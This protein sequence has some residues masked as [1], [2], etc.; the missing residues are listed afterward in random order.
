MEKSKPERHATYNA[1]QG[2]KTLLL[3]FTFL[4]S[5][6]CFGQNSVY[7]Y[8]LPPDPSVWTMDVIGQPQPSGCG[9]YGGTYCGSYRDRMEGDT[10]IGSKTYKKVLETY[11]IVWHPNATNG[12]YT[13][14]SLYHTYQG[15]VRQDTLAGKVFF[16]MPGRNTDTLLYSYHL[17]IGDTFPKCYL[18]H[19]SLT[20]GFLPVVR[21]IDTIQIGSLH[22]RRFNFSS[23]LN[24]LPSII[25]GVGSTEGLLTGLY[26]FFEGGPELV[27][28]NGNPI[29]SPLMY[30]ECKAPFSTGL[31]EISV[32]LFTIAPNPSPG[33]IFSI[34]GLENHAMIL[35][36]YS[37]LGDKIASL[38]TVSYKQELD[39]STQPK[40]MYFYRVTSENKL[41]GSGKLV[42]E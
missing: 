21:K 16:C 24:A 26:K 28:F 3:L 30:S 38:K 9:L 12:Y 35:E 2:I 10:L 6:T 33:G 20:T 41:I 11:H 14:D 19:D 15:A 42:I 5:L 36:V 25:Q 22:Y 34:S 31:E 7:P 27:C 1:I 8:P 29:G 40:G 17:S 23:T 4:L 37:V 13:G 18:Y 32:P 39:L